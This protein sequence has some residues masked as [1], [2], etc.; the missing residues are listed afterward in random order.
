MAL[1]EHERDL[2]RE[3]DGVPRRI[4]ARE[5]TSQSAVSFF[6]VLLLLGLI[7]W[8]GYMLYDK[9]AV[10]TPSV[11]ISVPLLTPEAPKPATTP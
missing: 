3:R 5:D 7:G 4:F 1:F 11:S 9:M 6:G 2:R 10:S 8:V